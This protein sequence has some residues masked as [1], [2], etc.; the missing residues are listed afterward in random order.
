[1]KN[2][3]EGFIK[4]LTEEWIEITTMDRKHVCW[5]SCGTSPSF[6]ACCGTAKEPTIVRNLSK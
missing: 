6:V 5:C 3:I 2:S 4:E 1:M